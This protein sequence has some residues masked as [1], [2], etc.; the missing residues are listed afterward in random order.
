[1]EE[2]KFASLSSKYGKYCCPLSG[3]D[4]D[5]EKDCPA[6]EGTFND[7][8]KECNENGRRLCTRKELRDRTCC[9]ENCESRGYWTSTIGNGT[10]IWFLYTSGKITLFQP[11]KRLVYK[12]LMLHSQ[13]VLLRSF[14]S[15]HYRLQ[16]PILAFKY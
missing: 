12:K 9:A 16:I 14:L 4:C 3:D 5:R 6:G 13:S 1:M 15:S 7:A 10:A 8:V 11:K 2:G